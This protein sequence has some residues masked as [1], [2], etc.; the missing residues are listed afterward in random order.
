MIQLGAVIEAPALLKNFAEKKQ[1]PALVE[2]I[3]FQ[4]KGL[5]LQAIPPR[6]LP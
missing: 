6:V 5:I 2:R 4:K 3:A 1:I